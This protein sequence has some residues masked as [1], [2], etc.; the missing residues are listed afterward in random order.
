MDNPTVNFHRS[1]SF[2][3]WQPLMQNDSEPVLPLDMLTVM[4]FQNS[5]DYAIV[6][7]DLAGNIVQWNPAAE[8]ILGWSESETIGQHGSLFFTME[9]REIHRLATELREATEH[10]VAIDERWHVRRNG[11][12]LWASGQTTALRQNGTNIGFAKI[13]RDRTTERETEDRLRIAQQAGRFGSFELLPASGTI[14]P[15][16][17][18][19]RLWGMAVKD[20]YPVAEFLKLILP[21]DAASVVT[22]ARTLPANALDYTEYRIVRPDT[23]EVRWMARRGE[24]TSDTGSGDL[25]YIGVSYDITRRKRTELDLRF[26]AQASAELSSLV[27]EQSTLDKLAFLA[28]PVFADWCAVD[29][30]QADGSLKRV[31]AAHTDPEKVRLAHEFHQKFPPDPNQAVGVWNVIRS[32][33]PEFLSEINDELLEKFVHD[34]RRRAVMEQL[35]FKSYIGVPLR[36]RGQTRGVVTFIS[37]ESGRR[38]SAADVALAEDLGHRAGIAIENAR[39]YT[40]LQKADQAKNV[41]LATL[42]HELRNPLAA[43][44]NGLTMIKLAPDNIEKVKRSANLMERQ[45]TQLARLVDE[46]MDMSRITTGKIQLQAEKTDLAAVIASAIDATRAQIEAARHRLSVR[47]PSGPLPL[48]ADP[49]RLAQVF[50]NL[51]SNAAKYTDQGGDI[52]LTVER[53]DAEF[54]VRVKDS[55]IGITPD[56]LNRVFTMFAQVT[57]PVDRS[58]GGLGIGLALVEG[59]VQLHGGRVEAHSAG[60]SQGSEFVVYLPVTMPE[61]LSQMEDRAHDL[62]VP[63]ALEASRP[64]SVLVVDDNVDAAL[65]LAETLRM[66]GH[67]VSV[68]HDGHAAVH[69]ALTTKPEVVLLDIGLPGI[70]GYEVARRIRSSGP[71][72]PV[73]VIALTGWSQEEDKQRAFRAGFDEHWAKPVDFDRLRRVLAQP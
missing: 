57:H 8:K 41:F 50:A 39:L 10:G 65:V 12:R 46:L 45:A 48:F 11:T 54:I 22:G 4:L 62:R 18:F 70:D 53:S 40:D 56:M 68:V 13:L 14:I 34:P 3:K 5:G 44:V 51:L 35:G 42:A 66:L 32:G 28:V 67:H 59:L 26:L 6:M 1:I 24:M 47:L 60:L 71:T 58:Q 16:E 9:D 36:A 43:V 17:Q 21:E 55:G 52:C 19:C 73:R 49:M 27:D 63:L 61:V 7:L 29:M 72:L 25:R 20:R 37:A 2:Q 15:S 38:Y 30:V 31:A 23:G 33:R 64:R 69:A